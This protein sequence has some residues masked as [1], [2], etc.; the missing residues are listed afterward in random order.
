MQ[1]II[2][3]A[4]LSLEYIDV[5]KTSLLKETFLPGGTGDWDGT[6]TRSVVSDPQILEH[7][8]YETR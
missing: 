2:Q 8:S 1:M 6:L 7:V 5:N 4:T 3:G